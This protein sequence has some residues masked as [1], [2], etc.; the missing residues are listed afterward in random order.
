MQPAGADVLVRAV[1]LEGDVRD[2]L[3]AVLGELQ[4][5]ALGLQQLGV[6]LG[7]RV[8]RLGEDAQEVGAWSGR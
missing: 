8:L 6:L 4:L 7:Q 3:D 1:H 2:R 5:D